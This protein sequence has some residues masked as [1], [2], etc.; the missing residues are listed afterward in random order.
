MDDLKISVS[1]VRGLVKDGLTP[2]VT[3]DFARA[4]G[5]YV[6][7]GKVVVARDTRPTGGLLKDSVFSGLLQTGCSVIDIGIAP[8]P[9][10]LL[11]VKE[12]GAVGGIIITASHNPAGWNGL[13]FVSSDGIFLTAHQVTK[14]LDIWRQKKFRSVASVSVTRPQTLNCQDV[15]QRHINKV[16]SYIRAEVI[17][18]RHFTVV[19][20]SCNGAGSIITPMLLGELGCR[21]VL[22][23]NQLT[24]AFPHNPEPLPENLTEL[25]RVVKGEKADIGFAQDPD[26]DRLAIVSEKGECIG[27]EYTLALA[28][29]FVLKKTPGVVVT[30]LSTTKTIDDLAARYKSSVIRTRIGEINV[31]EVMKRN[32]T[33]IGGEGNGGVI[34]PAIN[35]GRDSLAGIGVILQHLGESK[36]PLSKL[37]ATLPQYKMVKTKL[38]YPQRKI[39]KLLGKIKDKYKDWPLNQED[40]IKIDLGDS[41]VHI[42][43]SNTEPVVRIIAEAKTEKKAMQL[44]GAI[45]KLAG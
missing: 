32:N 43:P 40:G 16:L 24:G 33:V 25:C 9:T 15:Y 2:E 5:S 8:T 27:E 20:D 3:L 22:I 19:L 18:Q 14:L 37:V 34:I 31:V 7:G 26:A 4:F 36:M 29:R 6:K 12:F 23:N 35:Y 1:G 28:A 10:L 17:R 44:C 42:R 38:D 39:E 45:R 11:M 21:T 30:N 41:W 13:K